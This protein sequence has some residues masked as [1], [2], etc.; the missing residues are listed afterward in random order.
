M[1]RA[2]PGIDPTY[3]ALA[4]LPDIDIE[5]LKR[6]SLRIY[7]RHRLSYLDRRIAML[8]QQADW[9]VEEELGRY[10]LGREM[11]RKDLWDELFELDYLEAA[12][13]AIVETLNALS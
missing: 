5:R 1:A 2:M 4:S 13:A 7:L 11:S 9:D 12:R 10:Y 3:Y 8:V 6:D